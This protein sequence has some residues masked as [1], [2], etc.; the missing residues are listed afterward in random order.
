MHGCGVGLSIFALRGRRRFHVHFVVDH[1]WGLCSL[2]EYSKQ[3]LSSL[4]LEIYL[5]EYLYRRINRGTQQT[6][7][8][9]RII[10]VMFRAAVAGR[11]IL[12]FCML[13]SSMP[14]STVSSRIELDL[15]IFASVI[16][17]C[18]MNPHE[19]PYRDKGPIMALQRE[20]YAALKIN[21][22]LILIIWMH[23]AH[24]FSMTFLALI[25]LQ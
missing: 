8:D 22:F 7:N 17:L 9:K 2:A 25:H 24:S 21:R 5:K 1:S 12:I 3:W 4:H 20:Q 15:R 10:Y 18:F 11:T 6:I 23:L 14:G 16:F 19:S 13:G